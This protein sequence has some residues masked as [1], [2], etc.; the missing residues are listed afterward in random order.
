MWPE[1][2]VICPSLPLDEYLKTIGDAK[3]AIDTIVGDTQRHELF[4]KYG[5]AIPQ[6]LPAPVRAAYH[7][8]VD[9]GFTSR[10]L[11]YSVPG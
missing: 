5:Y 11:P 7:R 2:D 9:A 1:L 8:L 10:L 4:A 6:E 3:L